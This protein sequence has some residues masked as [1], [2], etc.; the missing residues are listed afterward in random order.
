VTMRGHWRAL[1]RGRSQ[2]FKIGSRALILGLGLVGLG[3]GG[4]ALLDHLDTAIAWAAPAV[5]GQPAQPGQAGPVAPGTPAPLPA[6]V[7]I[8]FFTIP[9]TVKTELRWGKKKLGIINPPVAPKYRKPFFI[10]R[11]RDSGPMDVL[12]KAEGFLPLNTRVYTYGDNK[13]WLK[14][15]AEADKN[16]VL[17]YKQEIPDGGADGAR[18]MPPLPGSAD[19]GVPLPGVPAG[20]PAPPAGPPFPQP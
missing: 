8:Y 6:K 11:P 13:V 20:P 7:K 4:F 18:P 16:K 3:A 15:I 17:G 14:L 10:E 5:P 12:A 19:G 9:P 2:R 1:A